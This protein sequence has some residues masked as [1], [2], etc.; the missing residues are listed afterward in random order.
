MRHLRVL[1]VLTSC[2]VLVVATGCGEEA[3]G[4]PGAPSSTA[5]ATVDPDAPIALVVTDGGLAGVPVGSSTPVWTLD[6]AVA[7]PDGSAI[8]AVQPAEAGAVPGQEL[9][10]VDPRTGSTRR[11]VERVPDRPGTRV[12]AVEPGGER[13]VLT[14]PGD[15][16]STLVTTLD[17]TNR[18]DAAEQVFEGTVEPEAFSLDRRL[19]FAARVYPDRY[20]VHV[21][22]LD[23]GTQY[24]TTGPDKSLP[25]E[26]MYGDVVQAV[27]NPDGTQLA[28]LYR[29]DR[30]PDHTA[31]V[32]LLSLERG[33]TVC[34]D[35]HAPFGTGVAGSDAI[36]WRADGTVAVGH[37]PPDPADARTAS[38]DPA[39]IWAGE[40]QPHYHADA[41]ADPAAPALPVGLAS[42]PGFRRFVGLAMGG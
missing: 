39:A 35:L 17:P 18:S 4:S 14:V 37:T 27:L 34:I 11:V 21:L 7:A 41:V 24:P 22:V 6:G 30:S 15:D 25:P 19:L 13:V 38:F 16:D 32:H 26:D 10:A 28:T 29:D 40:P 1:A 31:F 33:Q 3:S 36:E 12:A 2:I 8:F 5:P 20:H 42:V 9:V 23:D